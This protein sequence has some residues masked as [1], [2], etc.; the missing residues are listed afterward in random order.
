MYKLI[1]WLCSGLE[2]YDFSVKSRWIGL[3]DLHNA[4]WIN[5]H[6]RGTQDASRNDMPLQLPFSCERKHRS[7]P[8]LSAGWP[9]YSIWPVIPIDSQKPCALLKSDWWSHSGILRLQFLRNHSGLWGGLRAYGIF[10]Q[11][12][13]L[14]ANGW[15]VNLSHRL[16]PN[17]ASGME[18]ER[19]HHY[20]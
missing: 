15:K 16:H 8:R 9:R 1:V 17:R 4:Q 20:L 10:P 14:W 19:N 2:K 5:P 7:A 6:T 18:K 13:F 12:L 3:D 11:I